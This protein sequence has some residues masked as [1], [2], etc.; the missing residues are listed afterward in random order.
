LASLRDLLGADQVLTAPE[1]L[2][3][4]AFDGTAAMSQMPGVVVFARSRDEVSGVMKLAQTHRLPV[5]TRGS[6]TGLSGGSLPSPE[7]LVLCLVKMNRI[8]ELD[9]ANLT[10]SVEPG[11]TTA[12][13]AEAAAAAVVASVTARARPLASTQS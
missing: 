12:A 2:L 10:L 8:L 9:R 1:D 13:V 6:G 4:Y 3:T 7:C 5:V 11:A